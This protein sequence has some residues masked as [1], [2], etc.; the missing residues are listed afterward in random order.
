MRRGPIR[1]WD[2]GARLGGTNAADRAAVAFFSDEWRNPVFVL[3]VCRVV[4]R[5]LCG[6]AGKG[7][8]NRVYNMGGPERLSRADMAE[9]LAEVRGHDRRRIRRCPAASI[10]GAR[11]VASP[12]D[13]SM[14]SSALAAA[15]DFTFTPF[16]AA[17]RAIDWPE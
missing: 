14:D 6:T 12:A 1:V 8:L 16:A 13:I 3:D 9:Q 7:A 15:L 4:E 5:F 17:L 2:R 10:A 11:G